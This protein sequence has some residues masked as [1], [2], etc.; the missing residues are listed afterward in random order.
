MAI[1]RDYYSPE[2]CH[3]LV[4]DSYYANKTPEEIQVHINIAF[5]EENREDFRR[6][7]EARRKQFLKNKEALA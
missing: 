5:L 4:D 3:I 1:V 6:H 7:T 2:G